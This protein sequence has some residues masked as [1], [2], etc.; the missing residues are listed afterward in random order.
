MDDNVKKAIDKAKYEILKSCR[1]FDF[2][3]HLNTCAMYTDRVVKELIALT[4]NKDINV[5]FEDVMENK[6]VI[7]YTHSNGS[8]YNFK[9][10]IVDADY[11]LELGELKDNK[12]VKNIMSQLLNM[13]RV[14]YCPLKDYMK[15]LG[16]FNYVL[17]LDHNTTLFLDKDVKKRVGIIMYK[18]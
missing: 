13:T 3:K 10:D 8:V 12:H 1:G 14:T 6:S 18:D 4:V 16:E 17:Q 11:F 5:L 15:G 7:K 9:L 2:E